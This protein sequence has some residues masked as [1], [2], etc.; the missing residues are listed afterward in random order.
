[1]RA[2]V[3]GASGFVG[4]HL[5]DLLLENG[6]QVRGL[7]RRHA[8]R[9]WRWRW[10]GE[11]EPAVGDVYDVES[12][13]SAAAGVDVVFHLAARV[14]D[15]GRW[16]EFAGATINGTR[17]MLRAA[18][19]AK[20]GRFVHFSTV[21]V[22]DDRFARLHRVL[23]EDAPRNPPGDRHFGHYARAK[24]MAEELVWKCHDSGCM[25]V[26]VLRPSLIYGPRDGSILPRLIEYL[27]S[28]LAT[29]IGRGNPVIDPIEV[30]DVARCALAAATSEQ[31][32]GRAYNVSPPNE[33]GVRDFY[34]SL[35][36]ALDIPPPRFTIP[37]TAIAGLTLLTENVARLLRTRNPPMLTWAGLALFTEDR[38]YDSSRAERELGWRASITLDDGLRR[39]A[40]W[41]N[42]PADP[43]SVA[44]F[45]GTDASGVPSQPR[46]LAKC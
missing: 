37:Y 8:H 18:A 45:V 13:R 21:N 27:R 12:L 36:R 3:T 40:D 44:C 30:T 29:W 35:C 15:W 46:E 32:I 19:E 20:V 4:S 38:H 2:L 22:Y 6:W 41:L 25:E 7:V 39:Y 42:S 43:E 10:Q 9:R 11:V 23:T 31:S 1:M 34:R 17:N 14:T 16:G 5:V 24:A 33:I 26:T 28:P